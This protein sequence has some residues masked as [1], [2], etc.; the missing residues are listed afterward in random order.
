MAHGDYTGQRKQQLAHQFAEE[1]AL[2]ARSQTLVAQVV[3]EGQNEVVDLFTEEDHRNLQPRS[4]EG[5]DGVVELDGQP[6]TQ[7][8]PR[9]FRASEDLD[10]ITVGVDREFSLKAGRRYQ[11]PSWVV[12]HLDNQGLVYH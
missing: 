5:E 1:Q 6:D 2:A 9:E 8:Q 11:A 4:V 7:F 10:Q 3:Q 12:D